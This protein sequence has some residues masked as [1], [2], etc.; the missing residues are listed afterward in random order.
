MTRATERCLVLFC[1]VFG[2]LPLLIL[3]TVIVYLLIRGGSVLGLELIFGKVPI[4]DALLGHR[5]VFDGLFP[6]LTG[7]GLLVILALILAIIPGICG[8]IY[9]AEYSSPSERRLLG[10]LFDI[11]AGLP[12]IVIGL[13]G[14]AL[15]ILLHRY[16]P[17]RLGP[18]LLLSAMALAFLII[19]YLVRTTE[20]SLRSIPLELRLTGP[21]LGANKLQNIVFVLLPARVNDLVGGLILGI[22]RAAEDT[23]VIMLTGAVASAGMVRS[24]LEQYEA[25]PF[26]IYYISSQ[27]SDAAE[28]QSG[29]GAAILLFALCGLLFLI[30]ILLE[31]AVSKRLRR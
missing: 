28:L 21:A 7:T 25:L 31:Q 8:G 27:Y 23:A 20:A 1:W 17:G 10:L 11:I 22:G 24:V 15:T 14:F 4:L 6:A 30:A 2:L 18:C 16:F 26:Y 3:A 13:A 9:L 12:S 5:Q 19:P 29:F